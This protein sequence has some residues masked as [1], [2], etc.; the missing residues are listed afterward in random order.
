MPVATE[1]RLT[2]TLNLGQETKS[3]VNERARRE[4][5]TTTDLVRE[6]LLLYLQTPARTHPD[7]AQLL[8]AAGTGGAEAAPDTT[9]ASLAALTALAQDLRPLLQ[10]AVTRQQA[11]EAVIQ[12]N[13]N[14]V[15]DAVDDL[16]A[17]VGRRLG[18]E[19]AIEQA[20]PVPTTPTQ[21]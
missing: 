20:A 13:H 9:P 15:M 3:A 4:G 11:I 17:A 14:E 16:A 18:V 1:G 2:L 6:A 8:A 19:L 21:G 5:R 10:I 7:V 12:D